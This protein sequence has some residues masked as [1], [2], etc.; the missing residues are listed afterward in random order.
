MD[1]IILVVNDISSCHWPAI[2]IF[3]I[4]IRYWTLRKGFSF[5]WHF[6]VAVGLRLVFCSWYA[7][8]GID[9]KISISNDI[10]ELSLAC[11]DQ[12]CHWPAIS[13]FLIL[14]RYWTLRKGFSFE[15]HFEVAVGLRLV[16]CS[17]YA[18]TGIDTKISISNDILEL[19]LACNDQSCHWPAISSFLI[20]IR[21]WNLRK[22]FNSEWHFRVAVFLW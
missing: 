8:T 15:W 7:D 18:D 1:S 11:N 6:G 16:F 14:I 4:L 3:L 2:S 22:G 17:W 12:S 9:T 13:I 10:L 20:L 5:E 21:H 19:S